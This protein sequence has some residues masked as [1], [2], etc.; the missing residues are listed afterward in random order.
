M[1]TLLRI[2]GVGKLISFYRYI[3]LDAPGVTRWTGVALILLVGTIHLL[4]AFEYFEITFYLGALFAANAASSTVAAVGIYRG[5]RTWGW[6]LGALISGLSLVAYL[7]SRTFGL[8][9]VAGLAGMW[10]EP[11]GTVSMIVEA[12]FI[13]VYFTVITGMNVAYPDGRNWR[14]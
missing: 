4:E 2:T 13:T 10:D 6:L 14:D 11:L 7:V 1:N 9:G 12:L 3:Y 5:A 8:P